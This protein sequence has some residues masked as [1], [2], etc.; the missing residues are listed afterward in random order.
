M[1]DTVYK[2]LQKEVTFLSHVVSDIMWLKYRGRCTDKEAIVKR[3]HGEMWEH[4]VRAFNPWKFREESQ[5]E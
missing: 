3:K 5:K 1:S 2:M 4:V